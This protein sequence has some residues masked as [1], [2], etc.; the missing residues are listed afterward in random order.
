MP[1]SQKGLLFGASAYVLWG[2][3]T[4]YWPLLSSTSA[5]EILAH[6]MIWSLLA[7]LLILVMLRHWR[8]ILGVLRSPRQLLLIASAATVI[9][10]N[11]GLFIYAVNSG[12]ALQ[13]ALGYFINP[14]VSVVFG[15]IVFTERL[16]PL[17]WTAVALG[18]L[19]VVVLT[20]D[21][22]APPWLAIGLALCFATYGVLK[23]FVKL[24]GV[25]SLTS[26]T[27]LMFLPAAGYVLALH[28]MG[29]GTFGQVSVAH[30]LL[31]IGA[32][33]VTALPLLFFGVAVVRIPL[34]MI[35]LLQFIV[36][37]MQFLIAWLIFGEDLPPS[38][39]I[40]FAIVWTAL[41]V[42]ATD[43]VRN[44]RDLAVARRAAVGAPSLSAERP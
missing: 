39:W 42:F 11:W 29:A 17:Q 34:S 16:R 6:R 7:M 3:S 26:E 15:V 36:P 2:L 30:T 12:N 41:L 27:M 24:G 31:L 9:S 20:F 33:A 19:A 22:G 4:L 25:E 40:G 13:A 5:I 38:R 18:A 14:L 8:W 32:G 21:Y 28:A 1:D 44:A 10:M 43:L 37:V 23:K 35:G